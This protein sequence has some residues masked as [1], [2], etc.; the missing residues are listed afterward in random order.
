MNNF[1]T[2]FVFIENLLMVQPV[3]VD[4]SCGQEV[5]ELI[6]QPSTLLPKPFGKKGKAT[7]PQKPSAENSHTNTMPPVPFL[8]GSPAS[9]A[10]IGE[11]EGMEALWVEELVS[12]STVSG[13]DPEEETD[14]TPTRGPRRSSFF[15]KR[16]NGGGRLWKRHAKEEA[17][18]P[19]VMAATAA[20]SAEKI[21]RPRKVHTSIK[22]LG[23]DA[24]EEEPEL[25]LPTA[26]STTRSSPKKNEDHTEEEPG[27]AIPMEARQS[28][29]GQGDGKE[30]RESAAPEAAPLPPAVSATKSSNASI[31][32]G[33]SKEI[34]VRSS[35]ARQ[36]LAKALHPATN[37]TEIEAL[38]QAAF[39]EATAARL[40]LEGESAPKGLDLVLRAASHKGRSAI[41]A[42]AFS[43]D[44]VEQQARARHY[45]DLIVPMQ[46]T[47][48]PS[49]GPPSAENVSRSAP[50][51]PRSQHGNHDGEVSTL[52][53][54]RTF[55]Q[56]SPRHATTATGG[57]SRPMSPMSMSSLNEILD[58]PMDA[59]EENDNK[60]DKAEDSTVKYR[61]PF[62]NKKKHSP[63]AKDKQDPPEEY[64]PNGDYD[65][66][67]PPPADAP[68]MDD[69]ASWT[70]ASFDEENAEVLQSK[71]HSPSASTKSRKKKRVFRLARI[72]GFAGA[73]AG[74]AAVASSSSSARSE[75]RGGWLR[76]RK[77]KGA[78]TPTAD[79]DSP[80]VDQV[81]PPN[82]PYQSMPYQRFDAKVNVDSGSRTTG[83]TGETNGTISTV[84]KLMRDI[85]VETNERLQMALMLDD[86]EQLT[87]YDGVKMFGQ[88]EK[89]EEE[90]AAE[91][92]AAGSSDD[93]PP[94]ESALS[95]L[96]KRSVKIDPQFQ[97]A[98]NG[99]DSLLLISKSWDSLIEGQAASPHDRPRSTMRA[100]LDVHE[101]RP[102]DERIT[103]LTPI[104]D[105]PQYNEAQEQMRLMPSASPAS[106]DSD[107]P[108]LLDKYQ[109][110]EE[111]PVDDKY[112]LD[113]NIGTN[114]RGISGIASF[115]GPS[116][117]MTDVEDTLPADMDPKDRSHVPDTPRRRGLMA[118]IQSRRK[119]RESD[120]DL[121][122]LKIDDLENQ[123]P[124]ST[125]RKTPRRK[126]KFFK[127]F[128][129]KK[130]QDEGASPESF[131]GSPESKEN[132]KCQAG[133]LALQETGTMTDV[134]NNR[135]EEIG[136]IEEEPSTVPVSPMAM[137][138]K[139]VVD[140]LPFVESDP[141]IQNIR[142]QSFRP[143]RGIDPVTQATAEYVR[144]IDP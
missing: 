75:R 46:V 49:G 14:L 62:L 16:K 25:H 108:E 128:Q 80:M 5:V 48:M 37:V 71:S 8:Q 73:G 138:T 116:E 54:D 141:L 87:S 34:S 51:S 124:E 139:K 117:D 109:S 122:D 135:S 30:E 17:A 99:A 140:D 92:E 115:D 96:S 3:T 121:S 13:E 127:K 12:P 10:S 100:L 60:K 42:A 35:K 91:A 67:M 113:E 118:R 33:A 143:K 81:P 43:P 44:N 112:V 131:V 136:T 20:T 21:S 85:D 53:F 77:T 52:G 104:R 89:T 47:Q 72:A 101:N 38:A 64:A 90:L 76:R 88:N 137:T 18:A 74:A 114:Y 102:L 57:A 93:V 84:A 58:G 142:S 61:L 103:G 79:S 50:V 2:E 70:D 1:K 105:A 23:D 28:S 27:R 9:N 125:T 39:A 59:R 65:R 6:R 31:Q 119:S 123:T 78:G 68:P 120:V 22:L 130:K 94:I 106:F 29:F 98:P 26:T 40:I 110:T 36:L 41:M 144:G 11:E 107:T 126:L 55:S 82:V 69:G 97:A 15:Q 56:D 19:A 133:D 45:M 83:R 4:D 7:L 86:T 63:L 66:E 132:P 134:E 32:S 111:N 24:D 95:T 129:S